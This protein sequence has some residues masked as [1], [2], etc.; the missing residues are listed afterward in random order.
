[1]S[2]EITQ[3]LRAVSAG[4]NDAVSQLF[5]IV[6]EDL[7]ARAR[8]QLAGS[9]SHTLGATALVHEAYLKLTAGEAPEWNDRAHFYGVAATAMRHI[10][11]DHA[12]ARQAQRRGGN[13]GKV[14]IDIA[15]IPVDD[16]AESLLALDAA[17]DALEK[18]NERLAKLVELRFFAGL[19]VEESATALAMSPRTVKRDWRTARAFIHAQMPG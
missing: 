15:Q 10:S 3:L 4:D 7:R 6:Y 16:A 13:A 17:L 5:E 9:A 12:R 14:N 8:A 19:S 18:R 1:M 11:I 2:G